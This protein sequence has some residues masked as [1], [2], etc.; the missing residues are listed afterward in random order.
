MTRHRRDLPGW[1]AGES[2]GRNVA[3]RPACDGLDQPR[4]PRPALARAGDGEPLG[5]TRQQGRITE[6]LGGC[7]EQ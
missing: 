3:W 4:L 5:S 6:R 2:L 1:M 7:D